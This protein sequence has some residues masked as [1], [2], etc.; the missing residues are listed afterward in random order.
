MG[1]ADDRHVA[2]EGDASGGSNY[3]T[4]RAGGSE[5]DDRSGKIRTVSRDQEKIIRIELMSRWVR[6][7]TNPAD[8]TQSQGSSLRKN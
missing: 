7:E 8:K 4:R 5:V 1:Q 2:V 6:K 3:E